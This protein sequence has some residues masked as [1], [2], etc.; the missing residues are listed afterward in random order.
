LQSGIEK[1]RPETS[2]YARKII[3]ALI[4]SIKPDGMESQEVALQTIA[5]AYD[6]AVS[7]F[8]ET[9]LQ[10]ATVRLRLAATLTR[11]GDYAESERNFLTAIPVLEAQL[12]DDHS[13]TLSA[14]NNLGYLYAFSGQPEKAERL[15]RQLLERQIAKNGL[16]H[17]FVGDSYQNLAKVVTTQGRYGE[18]IPLHRKAYDVY[19]SVLN[20]DHYIIAF[21]LL[22]ISFAQLQLENGPEAE[23]TAREALSR[24]EVAVPGSFLEGVAKCLLGLA[25]EKQ[26]RIN[27]GNALV[28]ASH[29]L[30]QNGSIPDPYPELCR[31]TAL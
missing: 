18:S 12:G 19:K 22:S 16:I 6:I 21:P 5:E 15:Y 23:L 13:V 11:I 28:S 3:S 14:L 2:K 20:N 25:L 17:R 31:L 24:F 8:G 1:L 7:V 4:A 30:M 29:E 26:G 10:A 9:S 27:E